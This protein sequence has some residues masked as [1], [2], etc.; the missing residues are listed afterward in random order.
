MRF[1]RYNDR[2]MINRIFTYTIFFLTFLLPSSAVNAQIPQADIVNSA[3]NQQ[4]LLSRIYASTIAITSPAKDHHIVGTFVMK[5]GEN[6]LVGNIQYEVMLLSPLPVVAVNTLQEDNPL[7]YDRVRAQETT[8]LK[9]NEVRTIQFN[10]NAPNVPEGSYRIRIQIVTVNDRKLG[11]ADTSLTMGGARG[12]IEINPTHVNVTSV[13]PIDKTTGNS[14]NPLYGVNIQFTAD[15]NNP[16]DTSISGNIVISTKKLLHANQ[17]EIIETSI[18][19]S[20]SAKQTKPLTIPIKTQKDPGAYIILVT[21][22]NKDHERISGVAE[23]R[24]VVRGESASVAEAQITSLPA[25]PD[26]LAQLDFVIG[27]SAD[28]A[29]PVAGTMHI[30]ITDSKGEVSSIDQ[31]F[32]M[33]NAN[34]LTG[35]ASVKVTRIICGTPVMHIV[36]TSSSGTELENYSVSADPF[37][38]P[39][40]AMPILNITTINILLTIAII[41]IVITLFRLRPKK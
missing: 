10:Y 1:D 19:V 32:S 17:K 12:F 15:I 7:I 11:W 4:S 38:N 30:T 33:S 34:P 37:A 36:L 31:K 18:P 2:T 16:T 5:N 25:T 39:S 22:E 41:V 24:Y 26:S 29:T 21:A 9:A 13:D 3:E 6:A 8:T 28:R 23:Y 27:G 20:L 40:C 14:W 35:K